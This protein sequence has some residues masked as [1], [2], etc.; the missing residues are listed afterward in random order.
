MEIIEVESKIQEEKK[1]KTN[2]QVNVYEYKDAHYA[3]GK[4]TRYFLIG[5]ILLFLAIISF[6]L[7]VIFDAGD[8]I[9]VYGFGFFSGLLIFVSIFIIIDR[10]RYRQSVSN[11][12]KEKFKIIA[13]LGVNIT[14]LILF[15]LGTILSGLRIIFYF[16]ADGRSTKFL[17]INPIVDITQLVISST[18]LLFTIIT[19]VSMLIFN[20]KSLIFKSIFAEY[21]DYRERDIIKDFRPYTWIFILFFLAMIFFVAPII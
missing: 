7:D 9:W 4:K 14:E 13:K 6:S 21:N 3:L 11:L 17:Q 2:R 12:P 18:Y 5:F 16:L 8:N 1:L 10:Y 20:K 19:F 15:I